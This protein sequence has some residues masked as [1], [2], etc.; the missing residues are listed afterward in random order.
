MTATAIT[1][2][3]STSTAS[4]V[5][6]GLLGGAIAGMVFAMFE[7]LASVVLNGPDAFFMPLRMIAGIALGPSALDAS[8]SL[9]LAGAVGLMIHMALSMMY[10]VVVALIAQAV[11]ALSGST[12]ALVGFASAMGFALWILNFFL[13][14][15]VFG[16][17]WFPDGQNVA[18]QVIAHTVMFGTVLGALLDRLA[19]RSA[20]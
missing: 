4:L 2:T 7:M 8:T 16:W 12:G 20:R 1:A 3:R 15:R 6:A 14:A 18:V 11:P 13:L 17:S 5:R 9:V 19:F 10:G